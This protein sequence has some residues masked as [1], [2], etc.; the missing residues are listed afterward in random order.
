MVVWLAAEP[1]MCLLAHRPCPLACFCGMATWNCGLSS[2]LF[3]G[4]PPPT[5]Y[6]ALIKL[7]GPSDHNINYTITLIILYLKDVSL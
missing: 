1:V 2:K 6:L 7:P 5:S 4:H 3:K